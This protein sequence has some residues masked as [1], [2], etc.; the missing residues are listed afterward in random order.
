MDLP[1]FS[2]LIANYNNAHYIEQAISSVLEQSYTNWE[3]VIMDDHSTDNSYEIIAGYVDQKIRLYRN[4]SNKGCGYTKRKLVELA[5]GEILGFLDSDD[6]LAEKAIE[7][8]VGEH[9]NRPECSLIYSTHYVCDP[10]LKILETSL[11]TGIIPA[12]ESHLTTRGPRISHFVSFKKHYYK[13]TAGINPRLRI[14]EDQD[15]YYKLEEAGEI[16]FVDEPL[17]FYRTHQAGTSQNEN[18]ARGYILDMKASLAAWKRRKRSGTKA[19]LDKEQVRERKKI[20]KDWYRK[21]AIRRRNPFLVLGY[22]KK[23]TI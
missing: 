7:T 23:Y 12:D 1:L 16:Y 8:M 13:N 5:R 21:R 18:R 9:L 20:I 14:A 6:R 11:Y 4:R 15:I 19:N 2:I 3:I 17:Y 10:E 22:L